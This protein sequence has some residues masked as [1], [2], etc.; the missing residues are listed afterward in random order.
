MTVLGRMLT[1]LGAAV[2][3]LAV[4]SSSAAQIA[5]QPTEH[6]YPSK[7]V[8]MLV[9][10]SPGGGTDV[11]ARIIGRKLSEAWNQQVVVDNRPGAGGLV[12]FEL[13]ARANPDGYTLLATS[14]SFAIQPSISAKLPFDPLRDFA[15]VTQATSAPYLLVVY[16]GVEAKS[17]SELIKLAKAH[18]GK[19]NYAS[20]GIGSAQHLTAELFRLM[21]G[22][23]IV[24]VPFKG[25][26]NVPDVI[27]GRVQM[28][29]SGLPQAMSHVQANR[30]RALGVTT[31]A[32][33]SAL[34]SIPTL[35][36]AGVPGFEV[37]IWYGILA[38]GRTPAPIVDKL[39]VD[40]ARALQSADVR[41]QLTSLGLEPVGNAPAAFSTKIRAEIAQWAKVAK[42]AGVT[43][44]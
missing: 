27:A 11:A 10:F 13:T 26:V 30:L 5:M 19:L 7:P 32:R 20:G 15:P 34:P 39:Y 9:G 42:Q 12:A 29:F 21:A 25:A 43:P 36:E 35:A 31:A 16:P 44:E 22:I 23:S 4:C 41:Q 28:L 6:G 33:S 3:F 37:T 24:H 38:T 17:L 14:P 2:A 18:P 40:L 8:R 1:H